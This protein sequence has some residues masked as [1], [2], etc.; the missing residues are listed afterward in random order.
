M[1]TCATSYIC[2]FA[3]QGMYSLQTLKALFTHLLSSPLSRRRKSAF[4]NLTFNTVCL[5]AL[6]CSI[7][8]DLKT[9]NTSKYYVVAVW[10]IFRITFSKS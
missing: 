3:L 2:G 4:Q 1:I 5:H 6:G 8:C 10:D 9:A 7:I